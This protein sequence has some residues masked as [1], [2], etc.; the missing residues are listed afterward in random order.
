[1]A[2]GQRETLPQ[3]TNFPVR[4][5]THTKWR[6]SVLVGPQTAGL[7]TVHNN[8]EWYRDSD[9]FGGNE[10]MVPPNRGSEETGGAL[11]YHRSQRRK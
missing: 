11:S 10:D 3:N 8:D 2:N 1:M 9:V 7:P 5:E 4:D 6:H